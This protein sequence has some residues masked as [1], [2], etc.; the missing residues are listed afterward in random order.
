MKHFTRACC[1]YTRPPQC[2][3]AAPAL[4]HIRKVRTQ[5]RQQ[6]CVVLHGFGVVLPQRLQRVAPAMQVRRGGG[7]QLRGTA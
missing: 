5:R 7:C 1:V 6:G 3:Q 2:C 4:L